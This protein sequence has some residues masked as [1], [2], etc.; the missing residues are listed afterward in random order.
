MNRNLDTIYFRIERDNKW[1]N[2]C[3]SDLT[4]IEMKEV[5]VGKDFKYLSSLCCIL[6]NTIKEIGEQLDLK[7]G[8]D[9]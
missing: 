2:I 7:R 3:F 5:L 1:Q 9:E 8:E 6:G 4:D